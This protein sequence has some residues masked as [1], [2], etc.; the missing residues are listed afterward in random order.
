[1]KIDQL[2]VLSCD[3]NYSS[4]K[5]LLAPFLSE[6]YST[7]WPYVMAELQHEDFWGLHYSGH[8]NNWRIVSPCPLAALDAVSLTGGEDC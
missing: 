8:H 2:L 1:M 6:N 7:E 5:G 4:L 3:G